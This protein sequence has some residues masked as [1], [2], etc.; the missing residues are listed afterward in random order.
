M[1]RS[2]GTSEKRCLKD[3]TH[4]TVFPDIA[5]TFVRRVVAD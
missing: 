3:T 5:M 1:D 4:L 2:W